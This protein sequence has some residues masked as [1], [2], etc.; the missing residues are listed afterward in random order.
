[1]G[2]GRETAPWTTIPP[3]EVHPSALHQQATHMCLLPWRAMSMKKQG[4]VSMSVSHIATVTNMGMS[5][6]RVVSGD[7]GDVWGLWITGSGS[8]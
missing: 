2:V 6:L 4:P 5:L 1:M 7:H 8:S 3:T